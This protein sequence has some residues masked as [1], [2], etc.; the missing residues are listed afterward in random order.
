MAEFYV[1]DTTI[2]RLV[3]FVVDMNTGMLDLTFDETVNLSTFRTDQLTLVDAINSDITNY[4]IQSQGQVVTPDDNTTISLFLNETDINHIKFDTSLFT[5]RGN[6]FLTSSSNAVTDMS[7][8]MVM[9]REISTALGAASFRPDVKSP[10]L[11]SF[12]LDLTANAVILTFDEPVAENQFDPRAVTLLNG[13]EEHLT[14]L[15]TLEGI[16]NSQVLSDIGKVVRFGLSVMDQNE[17]KAYR[18]FAMDTS[19]TYISITNQLTVDRA[20]IGNPN[21]IINTT[22][23][24]RATAVVRDSIPPEVVNFPEF[25]LEDGFLRI[26]FNEPVNISSIDYERMSILSSRIDNRTLIAGETT[27]V[28]G[29]LRR[30]I[31]VQLSL[32]DLSYIKLNDNLATEAANSMLELRS[33]AIQDQSGVDLVG[34][35]VQTPLLF[36]DDRRGPRPVRFILDLNQGTITI[37]FNDVVQNEITALN[38]NPIDISGISIQADAAGMQTARISLTQQLDNSDITNSTNGYVTVVFIPLIDL[39]DLKA[40]LTL[41]TDVNNTFLTLSALTIADIRGNQ[42]DP[43]TRSDALQ[44]YELIADTTPPQLNAF[45]LD[46]DGMGNLMLFFDETVNQVNLNVSQIMLVGIN[47]ESVPLSSNDFRPNPPLSSFSIALGEMDLNM[48]KSFPN[49]GSYR[50]NTYISIATS[51]LNDTSGNPIIEIVSPLLPIR[52]YE[53]D[54]TRPSLR[55]YTLNMNSG[56]LILSFSETVNGSNYNPRQIT[57]SSSA[58]GTSL[59]EPLT[60]GDFYPV[61]SN[62]LNLNLSITDLNKLKQIIGLADN[63]ETTFLSLTSDTVTDMESNFVSRLILEISRFAGRPLLEDNYIFDTTSPQLVNFSLNL[64]SEMLILTFDETVN[65]SSFNIGQIT[66][67]SKSFITAFELI[68]SGDDFESGSGNSSLETGSGNVDNNSTLSPITEAEISSVKLSAGSENASNVVLQDSTEINILLGTDDLNNLKINANLATMSNNTFIS[69]PNSTLSDMNGNLVETIP[70]MGSKQ[71][72]N[73]YNDFISPILVRFDLNL[74]SETIS[75]AFSEVV[76]ASSLDVSQFTILGG[77]D[78]IIRRQLSNSDVNAS[79]SSGNDATVLTIYL[80]VDD[81]NEIKRIPNLGTSQLSSFLSFTPISVRD[82]NGNALIQ[83]LPSNPLPVNLFWNDFIDPTLAAF[84]LDINL[85]LLTLEFSETVNAASLNASGLV[86]M[87][88]SQDDANQSFYLTSGSRSLSLDGTRLVVNVSRQDLNDIKFL[89][90]LARSD[91]DTYLSISLGTVFDMNF[92]PVET[93]L[94]FDAI[95]VSTY[96]PDTEGPNLESFRLN[97]T[98]EVLTLNFDETVNVSSLDITSITLRSSAVSPQ[99]RFTLTGGEILQENSHI[100]QIQLDYLDLNAIKLN[101]KLATGSD[102]TVIYFNEGAVEDLALIPNPSFTSVLTIDAAT[103]YFPDSIGPRLLDFS[104]DL[105]LEILMLNFDEPVNISSLDTRGITLLDSVDG[106]QYTLTGG[107]STSPNGLQVSVQLDRTD[108]NNLKQMES[109]LVSEESSFIS[110]SPITI[111]DMSGNSVQF[112]SPNSAIDASFYVNDTTRPYLVAYDLDLNSDIL[113]LYFFETVDIMNINFTGLTLQQASNTTN[114]YSLTNGTLLTTED[115]TTVSFMLTTKDLNAIKS[116]RIALN[117]ETTWMILDERFISDQNMQRVLPIINGVNALPVQRYTNDSRAPRLERYIIDLNENTLTLSFSETVNVVDTFMITGLIILS[118]PDISFQSN[119]VIH[120]FGADSQTR[121]TDVY[122]PVVLINIGRQDLNQIKENTAL[123]TN[124]NNTFLTMASITIQDMQGNYVI[125]IFRANPSPVFTFVEDR[126]PPELEMFDLNMNAETM[127]LYFSESINPITLDI[128]QLTLQHSVSGISNY[129]YTLTGGEVEAGFRPN[130]TFQLTTRDL[131]EIK[132]IFQ[133][134]TSAMNT[135]LNVRRGAI[136]DI[137]NNFVGVISPYMG[138]PVSDYIGDMTDP[139]L[140][141]FDLDLSLE[142][143]ILTFDETVNSSSLMVS[144]IYIQSLAMGTYPGERVLVGGTVLTPADAIVMI[145]LDPDDLNYIKSIPNF[146]IS[147]RNTY[148]RLDSSAIDDM[149][150]N[151]VSEIMNGRAISARFVFPDDRDPVLVS[152]DLDMNMGSITLTFNETVDISSLSVNDI[153]LKPGEDSTERFSFNSSSGTRSRSLDQPVVLIEISD[154]DL[155]EIKF[156]L[157]L[158]TDE[159]NTYLELNN[160]SIN[161]TSQNRVVPT[162]IQVAEFNEDITPPM[163]L[164]FVFDLD[165]GIIQLTFS[166]TV[167]Y[168][169]LDVTQIAI[170]SAEVLNSNIPHYKISNGTV[171]TP[172]DGISLSFELIK[173]DLD[174]LKAIRNLTNSQYNTYITISVDTVMDVNGNRVVPINE[175]NATMAGGFIKDTTSPVL[176]DFELDM[177]AA[178]IFITFSETVD[179]PTLMLSHLTLQD[180]TS[181][182]SNFSLLTSTSSIELNPLIYINISKSDLDRLKEN[183]MVAR[184]RNTTYITITNMTILDTSGNGVVPIQ[185]GMA[186]RTRMF[187]P[188]QTPPILEGFDL[189][190]D[191]GLLTLYYSETV[192]I[193]S[194]DPTKITLQSDSSVNATLFTLGGGE[195]TLTDGTVGYVLLTFEDLNEIKRLDDLATCT[196]NDTF[197]SLVANQTLTSETPQFFGSGSGSENRS[198]IEFPVVSSYHIL[199]MAAN[200]V[201]AIQ[202]NAPLLVTTIGCI[203]DTTPPMLTNFSLNMNNSILTLTFDETVNSST[204]NLNEVIF[205]NGQSNSSQSYQLQ[206]GYVVSEN[207]TG[208]RV[209]NTI[210]SD[211][212]LNELKRREQLATEAS[213]TFILVTESLVLDMN[214]NR[215]REITIDNLTDAVVFIPDT[216]APVLLSFNLDL[217]GEILTL[218]FSETVNATSLN[219]SGITLQNM[220]FTFSRNL[221]KGD[222]LGPFNGG[223]VLGPNDPV[224]II[225]LD[226]SDLNYIK[227]FTDL[228]TGISNSYLSIES[229]TILDMNSNMVEEITVVNPL[230]V[231]M[232]EEDRVDPVLVNFKL[233]IDSGELTL[234]F[235]ETVDASTLDVSE[236]ILQ[237]DVASP[238]ND[239]WRFTA[240]SLESETFSS[241]SDNPIIILIIGSTDLNV[242]KRLTQLAT[243]NYTTYLILSEGAINDTNG[244]PIV[245]IHNGNAT[246]ASLVIPD[247]SNPQLANFSLDLNEGLLRLTFNETVNFNSL[248]VTSLTLQN[249]T[250]ISDSFVT[251]TGGT[252]RNFQDSTDVEILLTLQDQNDI[253][254]I[255]ALGT[256]LSNTYLSILSG[257]IKDMN[258]NGVIEIDPLEAIQ[259]ALFEEDMQN[260]MLESFDLNMNSGMIML[261]FDETVE[262]NSLNVDEITLQNNGPFTGNNSYTLTGGM[263]SVVD[264]TVLVIN[265]SDFDLNEIKRIRGLASKSDGSNAYISITNSTVVDMSDNLV[266]AVPDALAIRVNNFIE[267][268]TPPVLYAFDLDMN[269]GLLTL[270][271]SETVDTL[272]FNISEFTI[273]NMRKSSNE[274]FQSFTLVEENLITGDGT[275]IIQSLLYFDLNSIKS[276][277]YLATNVSDTFLSITETAIQDMNGN[278]VVPIEEQEA[279]QVNEYGADIQRP[280]LESFDLDMNT[281]EITLTFSETVDISSLDVVELQLVNSAGSSVDSS[282]RFSLSTG[283]N[284]SDWPIFVIGIGTEDLNVIKS[285][286]TLATFNDTTFM[287][288]SEFFIMDAAGNMNLEVSNL[289]VYIFTPDTTQPQLL[290]F[291]LDLTLDILVLTFDETVMGSTLTASQLTLVNT[292]LLD[293]STTFSGSVSNNSDMSNGNEESFINYTLTGG[294]NL[295]IILESV[296]MTINLTFEGRNEIKRLYS[297]ATSFAN[298]F[299]SITSLFIQDTNMNGVVSISLSSPLQVN[300]FSPDR[301]APE[302]VSFN[303]DMDEGNLTLFFT[304]TVNVDTLNVTHITLQESS[305]ILDDPVGSYSLTYYSYSLSHNSSIVVIQVSENNANMIKIRTGLAVNRN[306]SFIS[307]TS[308]VIADMNSNL[309]GSVSNMSGIKVTTYT[310]DAT[311]PVLREF[312]LNLTSEVLIMSFDESVDLSSIQAIDISLYNSAFLNSTRYTLYAAIAIGTDAPTVVLNLTDSQRDLD[313]IKLLSDLATER[314]NTFVYLDMGAI[315]DLSIPPNPIHSVALQAAEYFPDTISPELVDF[316][317]NIDDGILML[318]FNEVVNSSSFTPQAIRL[319]NS[320]IETSFFIVLTGM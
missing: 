76:N 193:F 289:Q 18:N 55:S 220:N 45:D 143:L 61:F 62:V 101:T 280:V 79:L 64:T 306:T 112:L 305:S 35:D 19:N 313:N 56:K 309:V 258:E 168:E 63:S 68:G 164:S 241:S 134:A 148:L 154:D 290:S 311:P 52:T 152:F 301:R 175:T 156:R 268:T 17:L 94:E 238:N 129:S 267:D 256:S 92:N 203:P 181:A 234:T 126:V 67:Q 141:N 230:Q 54:M 28:D 46:I 102:N 207:L 270:S 16:P 249:S 179:A 183:R 163:L 12:I 117:R 171:L 24:L 107:N 155:N 109:I 20:R 77:P 6:T 105:N 133:L 191:S 222:I 127:T 121:T 196:K 14:R 202:P 15:R 33:G 291:D 87:S 57:I 308:N 293:L 312:I 314:N 226:Q 23:P 200:P 21:A 310:R 315:S 100:V 60:G 252:I 282:F 260:P 47:G 104:I 273:Q 172:R 75:L 250:V 319:Q 41:G 229:Y 83:R 85:G 150:G 180:G 84:N 97:L 262:A 167:L 58:T 119:P 264:S 287:R 286:L 274:L 50:G 303:L 140:V 135:F 209:I 170:Q 298:T 231:V 29:S 108:L 204:L 233:D 51:A 120:Q 265:I 190:I 113:T 253:K 13:V 116:Q 114:Y 153:I 225:Q 71:V 294:D 214:G 182:S 277:S 317:T 5:T 95:P 72:D 22:V 115:S 132:R 8:N 259:A 39:N 74:T 285:I 292:P 144:N 215:N 26:L 89:T 237:S 221:L 201:I 283:S 43:I 49:L 194:L 123:A 162:T 7:G 42:A 34:S 232:F 66:I 106:L 32:E 223:P 96:I 137:N 73:F 145:Q 318:I 281:G 173:T 278:L 177:D 296:E 53:P 130:I 272:T 208:Q 146:A 161:D 242:I 266:N 295:P 118:E 98:S 169:T 304:E 4:T 176:E 211:I 78:S 236:I 122:S 81:L 124:E 199:D 93:I 269:F 158:V 248:N 178:L 271:F 128:S 165:E 9:P 40:L 251:L 218:S 235:S 216:M 3:N 1:N 189:N 91:K 125:P 110:V 244:N 217:S 69:F 254:R 44:A 27:Y 224:L 245:P 227:A 302:L 261:I 299:V 255:R 151:N 300:L 11:E 276:V 240:G 228:A 10:L 147:I 243:S 86:L 186:M 37:T 149:A 184:S 192:D 197:I 111:R 174:A 82:M 139:N 88:A 320:S 99:A 239:Q 59:S 80:G 263:S 48:V 30:E 198:D 210:I 275:S 70:M 136:Q 213:N 38:R 246:Q 212:D 288:L 90:E 279:L 205:Y 297:L 187:V 2:P 195:V 188:D 131:N 247:T 31:Q 219:I 159:N 36:V 166:E 103:G 160:F 257:A 65:A 307:F 138:I 284:S 25:N 142:R 316:H 206:S 157:D 185:D